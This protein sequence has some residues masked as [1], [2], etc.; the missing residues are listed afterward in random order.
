[1]PDLGVSPAARRLRSPHDANVP[2][3]PTVVERPAVKS[4]SGRGFPSLIPT[5]SMP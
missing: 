4:T 3:F 5:S 1:M 2:P